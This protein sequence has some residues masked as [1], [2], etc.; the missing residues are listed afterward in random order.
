M[1]L[2]AWALATLG[3]S[4]AKQAKAPRHAALERVAQTFGLAP[5]ERAIVRLAYAAERSLKVREAA[6]KRGGGLTVEVARAALGEGVDAALAVGLPLRRHALVTL[7]HGHAL[8]P[9]A[10]DALALGLGLAA[11]LDGAAP[12]PIAPGVRLVDGTAAEAPPSPRAIA[13]AH[14]DLSQPGIVSVEGCG[15]REGLGLAVALAKAQGRP[16]LVADAETLEAVGACDWAVLQ[17]LRREA[18]LD[19]APVV[20][21][22]AGLLGASW[23]AL[24][25]PLA[26]SVPLVVLTDPR[27][28]ELLLATLPARAVA[29]PQVASEPRPTQ[30]RDDGFDEVRRQAIRDAERALGLA[31]AEPPPASPPSLPAPL[32]VDP[33]AAPPP[34]PVEPPAPAAAPLPPQEAAPPE[35]APPAP[36]AAAP[37]PAPESPAPEPRV[38]IPDGA[39]LEQLARVATTTPNADQRVELIDQLKRHKSPAVVAA[40]RAN[41]ASPHPRVRAAAESAMATLFGPNWNRTRPVPKP[42]QPPRSDDDPGKPW[43]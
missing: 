40:L 31:P 22:Q 33:A 32:P 37:P 10:G 39:P 13:V 24:D 21:L 25:V 16:V 19:G 28:R 42:V 20:V 43:L 1:T 6:R 29:M 18:D 11:R 7:G 3:A 5:L 23:Q 14:G 41:L 17:A 38:E 34:S 30:P 27:P 26:S 15:R 4:K 35:A 36:E 2:E 8:A 12:S 9:R